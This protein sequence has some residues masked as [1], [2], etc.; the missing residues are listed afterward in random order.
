MEKITETMQEAVQDVKK[1]RLLSV[2]TK[3]RDAAQSDKEVSKEQ[4][5]RRRIESKQI[6]QNKESAKVK[7]MD[8]IANQLKPAT[9]SGE[10]FFLLLWWLNLE[11][12]FFVSSV[13]SVDF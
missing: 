5:K 10:S 9:S 3:F 12:F 6:K 13:D 11:N 7:N 4:A 2:P 8:Y 1:K